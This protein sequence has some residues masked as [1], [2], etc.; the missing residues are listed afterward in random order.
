MAL[1]NEE[2]ARLM[3]EVNYELDRF[4]RMTAGTSD[5]LR[6]AKVGVEGFSKAVR[7]APQQIGKAAGQ[8]AGAMYKGEQGAKAFNS[9]IDSMASAADSA[10]TVLSA[11]IPGGP[12]VKLVVAG[13]TKLAQVTIKAAAEIQKAA[14]AQGDA[15]FNSYRQLSEAGAAGA[16]GV[17]GL[18]EDARKAGLNILDMGNFIRNVTESAPDLALYAGTVTEGRKRFA[19]M[20]AEVFKSGERLER[21]GYSTD[22]QINASAGFLKLQQRMGLA[23]TQSTENLGKAAVRYIEEQDRLTK[24]T[25]LSRA[26]QEQGLNDAMRNQRFAA[27]ID[28]LRDQGNTKSMKQLMVF[29]EL[30]GKLGPT[31]Q[32]GFQDMASGMGL[33]S[34]EAAKANLQSG[35]TLLQAVQRIRSGAVKDDQELAVIAD[36]VTRGMSDFN[37]TIGR[38]SASLGTFDQAFGSYEE[39]RRAEQMQTEGFAKSLKDATNAVAEQLAGTE[40]TTAVMANTAQK[41][42]QTMVNEQELM[43]KAVPLAANNINALATAAEAASNALVKLAGGKGGTTGAAPAAG[44]RAPNVV[45]SGGS[46][47]GMGAG[48]AASGPIPGY[49]TPTPAQATQLSAIRD[50]IGKVESDSSGGYNAVAGGAFKGELTNMTVGEIKQL[51]RSLR[52]KSSGAVG[53][54]QIIESTLNEIVGK[55]GIKDEEKFDQAVQDKLANFLITQRG[56]YATYAK[57]PNPESKQRMMQALAGIW[58]GLPNA[59]GVLKGMPTDP[60]AQ[61]PNLSPEQRAR[62]KNKAGISW[63]EGINSFS[64]GGIANMPVSGGIAKLHGPEAVVPLPDGRT[65][66]VAIKTS[67]LDNQQAQQQPIDMQQLSKE[68]TAAVQNAANSITNNLQL[69]PILAAL[70]DIIRYQRENVN[71]SERLLRNTLS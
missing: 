14:G 21:L 46:T 17:A 32:K 65:I 55:V 48:G 37:K 62:Y 39:G 4:G 67:I 71:V 58:R 18:A 42:R 15:L 2:L 11:L 33:S 5:R 50:L 47:G 34:E 69:Q 19:D 43:Q 1:T 44:N 45:M 35:Q 57:N 64:K 30:M 29:N 59:P 52:G 25:G 22:A 6:D 54:Y 56:G 61:N 60:E 68:I 13:I 40:K 70:S 20:N 7:E 41:Q 38:S 49:G 16:D 26:Q 9:S 24:V 66:P 10:A 28:T 36:Q 23:Q 53:R 27:A 51:Q 8:M 31:T 12:A 63:E 3:E